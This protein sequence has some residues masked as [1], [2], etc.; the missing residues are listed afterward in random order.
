MED[1]E[2]FGLSWGLRPTE[3]ALPDPY[4]ITSHSR[5]A[6]HPCELSRE[7]LRAIEASDAPEET[8]RFDAELSHSDQ[9]GP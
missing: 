3:H 8:A 2:Q 5:K 1:F 7:D 4:S 9:P 6:L